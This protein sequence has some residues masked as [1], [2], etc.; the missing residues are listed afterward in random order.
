MDAWVGGKHVPVNLTGVFLL[1]GLSR[2]F[3]CH[4]KKTSIYWREKAINKWQKPSIH[5]HF[6]AANKKLVDIR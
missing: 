6:L 1:V 4:Y 2:K 3:Y 5:T